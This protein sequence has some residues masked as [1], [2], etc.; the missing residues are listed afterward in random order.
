ML[1]SIAIDGP[2]GVGKSTTARKTAELLGFTYIDTGA[3]YRAAALYLLERGLNIH[4]ETVVSQALPDIVISLSHVN[5]EQRVFLGERDVSEVI[6]TQEVAEAAS[7]V[8]S[9]TC[10][11]EKLVA[12]Q[13]QMAKSGNVVMDGRDIGSKVLP[14]AQV[15]I[16]LDASLEVRTQRRADDLKNRGKNVDFEEVKCDIMVRDER[17]MTRFDSPL[18]CVN[19][20][21]KIDTSYMTIEEVAER[22]AELARMVM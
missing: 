2:I 8:A 15:K 19:G 21:D 22:I 3:M 20:A 10:V 4:S 1:I 17:D 9:Y 5:G 6:R 12:V 7:I 14:N 16:Y 11:R 18:V 13:K